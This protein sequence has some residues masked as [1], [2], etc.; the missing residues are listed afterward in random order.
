MQLSVEYRNRSGNDIEFCL[1][2]RLEILGFL[3]IF[4][5]G[6]LLEQKMKLSL[7]Y[8]FF[9]LINNEQKLIS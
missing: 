1:A 3:M 5:L 2:M 4:T 7:E 8:I 6:K 9:L